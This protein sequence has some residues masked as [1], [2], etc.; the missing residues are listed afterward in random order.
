MI[1]YPVK[2]ANNQEQRRVALSEEAFGKAVRPDLLAMAVRYQMA[3]RRSGNASTKTRGQV[4]GGG[5]KPYRQKGTG[6]ARQGTIRAPQFRTGGIVFGPHP[7]DYAH[8]LSK[9]VRRLALQTALSA[10]REAQELILVADL[11]L[12]G[13]K[14]K[15]LQAIL[16]RLDVTGSVLIVIAA[17]DDKV[18]LS[19]RNIP[20]VSV[21]RPEGVNV[22]DLLWHEK[23]IL[24]EAALQK[25]EE[26]LG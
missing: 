7:R 8:K 16:K 19:A 24:T 2:D 22:H 13:I 17:A 26:R 9:R 11:G 14:T 18:E 23:V 12:E 4:R 15:A 5:R 6:N 20:G 21:I 1:D 3:K 25:I 10:K